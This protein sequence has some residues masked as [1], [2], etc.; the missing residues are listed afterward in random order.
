M[1]RSA[2]LLVLLLFLPLVLHG[3]VIA[4]DF[5]NLYE[6]ASPAIVQV[7][8]DDG[9]GSGF[10]VSPFGHIA[11]NFHVIRN[12]RYLAVQ[13]NDGRKVKA[14]V[15]AVNAKFDM[16][17][18]KVNSAIV[19]DIRPLQLLPETKEPGVKVGIPVVALG[20]PLNQKFLMTQGILSKVEDEILLGDFLLQAGNSGG[21]L[22][23]I[24]GMV[25]G[26]NTF[27]EASI[28]GAVRIATLRDLLKT[29]SIWESIQVEPRSDLLPS[30]STFRYPVEILNSKIQT[31]PLNGN[32]YRFDAGAFTVTAITPVLV[33]K[34][35]SATG[36]MRE[37][38]RYARRSRFITDPEF[39]AEEDPYYEWHRTTETTLD[40]AVTFDVRPSSG[41]TKQSKLSTVFTSP[42]ALV[43]KGRKRDMEFKGEFLELRIY[44]DGQLI[45]PV[46]PGRQIIEGTTDLKRNR[47]I[48]E[49]Y[50]GSYVYSPD[51]FMRGNV[52][53]FQVID[54]RKP[55]EIH[56]EVLFTADAPLIRQLRADFS[57]SPDF[58]FLKAP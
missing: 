13:F 12:S 47:F 31:E 41:P 8:T 28:S 33:G 10:L 11:T 27:G 23:N 1:K 42:L 55:E 52:F 30:L 16:A 34:M 35:Q 5:S 36:K 49:A 53:K 22:L 24:D 45:E 25:I 2:C 21:P 40:F 32:A 7:S 44:R 50:A 46:M 14:E 43:G 58:F 9:A 39:M 51:E 4:Y 29:D 37:I 54:A 6:Q 26:I 19:R 15:I 20:S 38:N 17:L 18:L 56:K 48:D 3:Q 57:Y